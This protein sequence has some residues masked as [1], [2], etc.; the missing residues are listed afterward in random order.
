[1]DGGVDTAR[2]VINWLRIGMEFTVWVDFD[3][4]SIAVPLGLSWG[5]WDELD[6][7]YL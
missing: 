7:P 2:I 6:K 1:M 4:D 5:G 3:A